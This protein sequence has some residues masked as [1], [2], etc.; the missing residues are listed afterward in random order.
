MGFDFEFLQDIVSLIATILG[1]AK[2]LIWFQ[3]WLKVK[4]IHHESKHIR[5]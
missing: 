3:Q 4:T 5:R 2:T 1:V